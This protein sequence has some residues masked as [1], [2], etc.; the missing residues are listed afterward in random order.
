MP[1]CGGAQRRPPCNSPGT[2]ASLTTAAEQSHEREQ[3][4]GAYASLSEVVQ[5]GLRALAREDEWLREAV[6]ESLDD[7]RPSIPAEEVFAELEQRY[8]EDISNE[9][10]GARRRAP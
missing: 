1:R 2:V 4:G 8:E 6:R 7:P 10:K 9:S 3:D 5:E